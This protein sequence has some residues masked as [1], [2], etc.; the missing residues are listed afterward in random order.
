M[1]PRAGWTLPRLGGEESSSISKKKY[2]VISSRVLRARHL[3]WLCGVCF[4]YVLRILDYFVL[5]VP[6]EPCA[7]I[8]GTRFDVSLLSTPSIWSVSAPCSGLRHEAGG[9]WSA[10]S[11]PGGVDDQGEGCGDLGHR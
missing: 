3:S 11:N 10:G 5:G 1:W 7:V 2:C 9:V 6:N 4:R 8:D